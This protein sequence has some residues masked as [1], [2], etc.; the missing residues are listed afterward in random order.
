MY[1][2]IYIEKNKSTRFGV[3]FYQDAMQWNIFKDVCGLNDS[4]TAIICNESIKNEAWRSFVDTY[5]TA[6]IC[7]LKDQ[8]AEYGNLLKTFIE[9]KQTGYTF[10]ILAD[11]LVMDLLYDNLSK[12]NQ[13][14]SFIC[15]PVTPFALFSDVTIR[16]IANDDGEILRKEIYPNAVYVD[17][18]IL[19]QASPL[20]FLDAIASAF[21]LSV[22]YKA[23][24]FEWMISNMYELTDGEE[25]AICEL[26]EKG[27]NVTNERIMKD[28]A[29]DRALPVYGKEFYDLLQYANNELSE[30]DLTSLSLVCQTYLSWKNDF[31]SMEEYYEIRD[32]FVFFGLSITETFASADELFDNIA[33]KFFNRENDLYIRKL[34]KITLDKAST[35][36]LVK[37]ALEQIYYDEQSNE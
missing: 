17:V 36:K 4:K 21:R 37:E 7:K 12:D 10:I 13:K 24:M 3:Y 20:D 34:G 32:M 23:S 5:D 27:F 35:N 22:S 8:N 29:K 15:V 6:N 28:T 16:P 19:T 1:E 30:A 2:T 14:I 18:S 31:L 11:T 9:E 33:N 25:T 26:L